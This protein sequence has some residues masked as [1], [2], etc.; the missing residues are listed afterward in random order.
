VASGGEQMLQV[1][2]EV[3]DAVR[4]AIKADPE[5]TDL[6]DVDIDL[7]VLQVL[8]ADSFDHQAVAERLVSRAYQD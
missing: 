7:N 1:V 8:A 2:K 4:E 6:A 5:R 3:D